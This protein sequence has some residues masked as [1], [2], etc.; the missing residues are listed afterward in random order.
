LTPAAADR[1][2]D[3]ARRFLASDTAPKAL[4]VRAPAGQE[5]PA[6]KTLK[7][8]G[9][10]SVTASSGAD[11]VNKARRSAD[12]DLIVMHRGAT[13]SDFPTMRREYDLGGLP[14]IVIADKAREKAM[15]KQ[16]AHDANVVV[17]TE[18]QFQVNELKA[19]VD[20]AHKQSHTVRLTPDER[21]RFQQ[22]AL[23]FL[24]S[25]SRGDIKGYSVLPA[26]DTVRDQL[27]SPENAIF[28]L[29]ILGRAPGKEI[30]YALAGVVTDPARAAIHVHAALELNRHIKTNGI[31]LDKKQIEALKAAH[32]QAADGTPLK[33]ELNVTMSLLTRP[34]VARTGADLLRFRPDPP[35]PPPPAPKP[36]EKKG[37]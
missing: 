4:I 33:M 1:V 26:I 30:Q 7:E 8:L 18:E 32:A 5:E 10:E 24:W 9:Y 19:A 11:A 28:A 34:A 27:A 31:A 23:A 12:F 36:E 20:D 14:T 37:N 3:I 16:L 13:E 21:K 17:I 2:V 25:M 35:A 22:V 6:R 15:K 29:D